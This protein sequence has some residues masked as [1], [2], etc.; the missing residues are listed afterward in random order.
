LH[1]DPVSN[2]VAAQ[3]RLLRRKLADHGLPSPIETVP[4]RGYRF[5]PPPVTQPTQQLDA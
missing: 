3:V 1:Q 2:V 5:G 4:S